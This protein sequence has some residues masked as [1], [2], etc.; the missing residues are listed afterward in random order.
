MVALISQSGGLL[1][2]HIHVVLYFKN[3]VILEGSSTFLR[4]WIWNFTHYLLYV[5]IFNRFIEV[6]SICLLCTLLN[7]FF[8]VYK[9]KVVSFSIFNF[10][11]HH[12]FARYRVHV[13]IVIL[14]LGV[15]C[16]K[17]LDWRFDGATLGDL[18]LLQ[19]ALWTSTGRCVVDSRLRWSSL[20]R[21]AVRVNHLIFGD[22][23]GLSVTKLL[24][25]TNMTGC[26]VILDQHGR[27]KL[28]LALR[29]QFRLQDLTQR[30][31]MVWIWSK[32][33]ELLLLLLLRI[34]LF[35]CI[36]IIH[37]QLWRSSR[38][39]CFR[40]KGLLRRAS[41]LLN[42]SL[43]FMGCRVLQLTVK[44]TLGFAVH[45]VHVL[46][47]FEI[48]AELVLHDILSFYRLLQLICCLGKFSLQICD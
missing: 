20:S 47:I 13:G 7:I 30:A 5:S 38:T 37:H 33:L 3:V 10:S 32:S 19:W 6:L 25:Y 23:R 15:P 14:R 34:V 21:V 1:G 31:I 45:S 12:Y 16:I 35:R 24:L 27:W 43:A 48:L 29:D 11:L 17:L 4:S 42:R 22:K 39:I 2:L 46:E 41:L 40:L 36:I 18:R 44:A 9:Q 8:I 26:V 28:W